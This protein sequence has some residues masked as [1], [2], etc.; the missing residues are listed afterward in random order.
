MLWATI[1]GRVHGN[2]N[3]YYY[4]E[5]VR[6]GAREFHLL[7]LLVIPRYMCSKSGHITR[8]CTWVIG[9]TGEENVC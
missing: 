6:E 1:N 9:R 3:N 7:G 2:W 5:R 4:R 8:E